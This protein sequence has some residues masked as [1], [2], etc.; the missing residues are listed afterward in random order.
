MTKTATLINKRHWRRSC[1]YDNPGLAEDK[2]KHSLL[3]E[4]CS[5]SREQDESDC[6]SALK[7]DIA[8]SSELSRAVHQSLYC[9]I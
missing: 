2:T 9:N 8:K 7:K 3:C 1:V 5:L 4:C 6:I